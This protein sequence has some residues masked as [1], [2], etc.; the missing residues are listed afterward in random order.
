MPRAFKN[1]SAL[2][3][4][5]L[6]IAACQPNPVFMISG[7]GDGGGGSTGATGTTTTGPGTTETSGRPTTGDGEAGEST[8]GRPDT[9]GAIDP[10]TT[11][12]QT[13]GATTTGSEGTSSG[14]GSEGTSTGSSSEGTST[15]ESSSSGEEASSTGGVACEISEGAYV[16]LYPLCGAPA[17]S[18]S[19]GAARPY[20]IECGEMEPGAQVLPHDEAVTLFNLEV[21]EV[22]ELVP[23]AAPNGFVEG[24]FSGLMLAPDQ[25]MDAQL[26]TSVT[27]AT[28]QPQGTCDVLASMWVVVEG[29]M[30]LPK[31]TQVM[32]GGTKQ[33][34]IPLSLI[35]GVNMGKPFSV[36]LKATVGGVVSAED[37]VYFIA[38]RIRPF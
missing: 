18:W 17:T 19:G 5:A 7:G 9:T 1:S 36:H 3:G 30:Q 24:S 6:A 4:A 12:G 33:L 20:D 34:S 31:M 22:L 38:P 23:H 14:T 21:C 2:A 11:T 13:T 28:T 27:C 29:Q 16:K 8:T 25:V 37:R 35:P 26:F 15:G 32:N 10:S